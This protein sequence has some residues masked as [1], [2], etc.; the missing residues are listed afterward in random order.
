M[1]GQKRGRLKTGANSGAVS[2]KFIGLEAVEIF[3][4]H[5]P[6]GDLNAAKISSTTS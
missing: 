2:I 1:L 5:D 4:R 6:K 3:V